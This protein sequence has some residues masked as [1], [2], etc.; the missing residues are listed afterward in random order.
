[1]LAHSHA[2]RWNASRLAG[3]LG[4]SAPTA[5]RYLAA[6]IGAFL[7]RP[8]KPWIANLSKRQ[9]K[10]PKVYIADSGLLHAL[11]GLRSTSDLLGHPICGPSWEG[12]AIGE[13]MRILGSDWEKCHYWATHQGAELDLLVDDGPRRYGLEFERTSAPAMTRSMHIALQDLGLER[14]FVIFPSQTRFE[15][16]EKV[17]AVGLASACRHGLI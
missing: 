1:M 3:S 6:L 15:I 10:A 11:L 13:I 16:S 7:V 5:N 9:V 14:M 17:E 2:G 4:V 8:L 12:F